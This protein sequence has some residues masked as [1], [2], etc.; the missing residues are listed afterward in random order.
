TGAGVVLR[1]G[2]AVADDPPAAKASAPK[3]AEPSEDLA[4]L[5]AQKAQADLMREL[6]ELDKDAEVQALQGM[7]EVVG[8][9]MAVI[10][11]EARLQQVE[12]EARRRAEHRDKLLTLDLDILK[13]ES[14][15][16]QGIMVP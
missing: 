12:A 1:P 8:A 14:L 9:R 5:M 13:L 2:P 3:A 10:E 4:R 7:Q 11:A 6:H 15:V 16:K